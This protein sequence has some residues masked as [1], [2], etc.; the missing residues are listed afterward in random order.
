MEFSKQYFIH[1]KVFSLPS[2]YDDKVIKMQVQVSDF[3]VA[4]LSSFFLGKYPHF[5]D[6]LIG[7]L[8]R[9]FRYR[10]KLSPNYFNLIPNQYRL[11]SRFNP[12]K[13]FLLLSIRSLILLVS[14]TLQHCTIALHVSQEVCYS[15]IKQL[16]QAE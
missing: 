6:L 11:F 9:G 8:S 5:P 7:M 14:Q 1:H 13:I 12:S 4:P 15:P 3:Y 10:H 2:L 16:T